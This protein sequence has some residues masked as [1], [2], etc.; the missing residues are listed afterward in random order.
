MDWN[1][2]QPRDCRQK[3]TSLFFWRFFREIPASTLHRVQFRIPVRVTL[4]AMWK[5]ECH[6][7]WSKRSLGALYHMAAVTYRGLCVGACQRIHRR[8]YVLQMS[9]GA[10]AVKV[11][12]PSGLCYTSQARPQP[13][14][15]L[16]PGCGS[17]SATIWASTHWNY[18]RHHRDLTLEMDHISCIS[19]L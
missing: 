14:E 4:W 15:Q 10:P 13:A 16:L 1:K 12:F 2:Q 19:L 9:P 6:V 18:N 17:M 11:V 3:Q 7:V 8:A 5:P